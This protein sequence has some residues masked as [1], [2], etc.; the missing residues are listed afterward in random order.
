LG[1]HRTERL[2]TATLALLL[3]LVPASA[4]LGTAIPDTPSTS[5]TAAQGLP[6]GDTTD[7]VAEDASVQP[8]L[9]ATALYGSEDTVLDAYHE[10]QT[11]THRQ[12][13]GNAPTMA[14]ALSALYAE[15]GIDERVPVDQI[16]KLD[17]LVRRATATLITAQ[18][19]PLTELTDTPSAAQLADPIQQSRSTNAHGAFLLGIADTIVNTLEDENVFTEDP[20]FVDPLGVIIIGGTDDNHYTPTRDPVSYR[21]P[22][23]VIEPDGDDTYDVPV[24][25]R[26]PLEPVNPNGPPR[27][28]TE[29]APIALEFD[30]NDTYNQK[31]ASSTRGSTTQAILLDRH[32]H[33][34]YAT[35]NIPKTTAFATPGF[36]Y[37]RDDT[38]NDTYH[39]Q[40]HGIAQGG[41]NGPSLLLGGPG[42]AYL[43]DRSGHDTYDGN[44][45]QGPGGGAYTHAYAEDA[46]AIA[47][48]RDD[49]GNDTYENN[50]IGMAESVGDSIAILEDRHGDDSYTVDYGAF[51][52]GYHYRGSNS[53]TESTPINRGFGYFLDANGTDTHQYPGWSGPP[54]EPTNNDTRVTSFTDHRYSAFVDCQTP[55]TADYPCPDEQDHVARTLLTEEANA[56]TNPDPLPP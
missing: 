20:T 12:L 5:P 51:T 26:A 33:D 32:G 1:T 29:I 42:S 3:V 46:G 28:Y 15:L 50:I 53:I 40:H 39:A 35:N 11:W 36:A 48:L 21:G 54:R 25:A 23:L 18:T 17:S 4:S 2:A 6:I 10:G 14:T 16:S 37:L 22:H 49:R 47:H 56:R 9:D 8:L 45:Q 44:Y 30:G 27:A 31:V 19:P 7:T 24:A 38:G 13:A 55:T 52:F 43:W 41:G 34:Q